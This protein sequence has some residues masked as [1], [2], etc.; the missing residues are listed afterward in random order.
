M[1][2]ERLVVVGASLAGLRAVEAA[3]RAGHDGE[4][5]LVGD[6]VHAP[7][8]RPPLSKAFLDPDGQR[9]AGEVAQFR[10]AEALRDELGVDLRLGTRATGLDTAA[11]EVLLGDERLPYDALV[12][13][14]GSVP[15]WLP[16]TDP[17]GPDGPLE[18]VTQLRTVEDARRVR[19]ALEAGA[20]I[21]VVGAGFIGSEVA[22]AARKRDLPVTVVEAL[23]VPL[24][25]SVGPE[26]GVA[27]VELHRAAGTDLRL[28]VG[29]AGLDEER[30]GDGPRRVRAVRLTDGTTLPADLVVLGIGVRPATAWL[31]DSGVA[32]HEGDRGVL[33]DATMATNVPGV[34]AAGDVAHV[35]NPLFD[36]EQHRLEHWTNAADHG[37]AAARHALDPAAAEP[38]VTVPYFW[39]DWYGHRLQFVGTPRA[40][41]ARVVVDE[42]STGGGLVVLYRRADRV[43]GAFVVDLPRV[44][45]KLRRRVLDRGPWD[46]AVAF[47]RGAETPTPR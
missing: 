12:I 28:G 29:V 47:A 44:V 34:W 22:S 27:C 45:M 7:Y 25:R 11:R 41:E 40:D 21:V 39:S 13:A 14:T 20:R 32:L 9:G 6:E 30:D 31:E 33:V 16:G 23:D 3:R 36:G 2:V 10:T 18:G 42:L 8:D 5:V 1:S 46:E 17:D 37:A 19:D 26:V 38:V 4:I 35:E 15:R 24:T 43:V